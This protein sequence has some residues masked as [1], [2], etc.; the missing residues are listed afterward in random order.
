MIMGP[1][2]DTAFLL[3]QKKT[4]NKNISPDHVGDTL[5]FFFFFFF[6]FCPGKKSHITLFGA[7]GGLAFDSTYDI[8]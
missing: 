6:F 8:K 2:C 3:G 7:L 5:F 4:K 1:V